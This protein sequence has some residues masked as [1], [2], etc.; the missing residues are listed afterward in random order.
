M[1]IFF[2]GQ[3]I[4]QLQRFLGVTWSVVTYARPTRQNPHC[5][6]GFRL[7]YNTR[8]SPFGY[9]PFGFVALSVHDVLDLFLIQV[10]KQ[11]EFWGCLFELKT[12]GRT[13]R[14]LCCKRYLVY[15][16]NCFSETGQS[17]MLPTLDSLSCGSE[18]KLM[19]SARGRVFDT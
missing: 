12:C 11:L 6:R 17:G 18:S 7:P 3:V 16:F 19:V 13:Y 4:V 10:H 2:R 15:S 1:F 14:R 8:S 9:I 5:A